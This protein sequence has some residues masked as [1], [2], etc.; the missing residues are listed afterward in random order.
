MK[1]LFISAMALA[2]L[3][4][5]SSEEI[6]DG[7]GD[8]GKTAIQ[9]KADVVKYIETKTISAAF[10]AQ[11]IAI[12]ENAADYKNPEWVNGLVT[13]STDGNVTFNPMKYYPV[14]GSAY[15]MIGITPRVDDGKIVDGVVTYTIDG[16]KDIM[17]SDTI[18]SSKKY[19]TT[20][21]LTFSPKLTKIAFN[22]TKDATFTTTL[23]ITKITV[24]SVP[25]S[26][27]LNLLTG[28]IDKNATPVNADL[29]AGGT[30]SNMEVT[31]A[32]GSTPSAGV[33]PIF[34]LPATEFTLNIEA[35][36]FPAGGQEVKI[37]PPTGETQFEAKKFYTITLKFKGKEISGSAAV[38]DRTDG[39]SSDVEIM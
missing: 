22:A 16:Q 17:L 28:A 6:L 30:F 35:T 32:D 5:C 26:L 10:D 25:T 14:D 7:G 4:S 1:K 37:T 15:S 24:K 29:V 33:N 38:T 8:N 11:L 23:N 9:L 36:G 27:D 13:I 2:A 19:V 39:G 31:T 20:K 21:K 18:I 12:K 34:L 3:V